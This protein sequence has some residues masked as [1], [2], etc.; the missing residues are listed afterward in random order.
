MTEIEIQGCIYVEDRALST[1]EVSEKFIE[2]VEANGW[3]FGGGFRT[4]VDG[5]Y[6]TD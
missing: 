1:D 2:F 5:Q 4:I 6:V 3:L